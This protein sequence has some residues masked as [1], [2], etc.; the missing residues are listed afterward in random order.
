MNI[1]SAKIW[2][3]KATDLRPCGLPEESPSGYPTVNL[4]R[5]TKIQFKHHHICSKVNKI[6]NYDIIFM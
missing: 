5:S 6:M 4:L 3:V 1:Q 2:S